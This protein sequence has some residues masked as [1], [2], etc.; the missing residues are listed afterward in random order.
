MPQRRCSIEGCENPRHAR[1]WCASH[2]HRWVR[3]GDP[4]H[5][6]K[7]RKRPTSPT[8][9]IDGCD[10]PHMAR[11]W[12]SA[13]YT[14]WIKTGDPLG[15]TR[16]TPEDRFWAKV[17]K[18]RDGCWVWTAKGT[19]A[20]YGQFRVDGVD[21]YAHRFSYELHVGPI[22]DGL[23]IDHLCRVTSCVNPAHLEPVTGA[24][25]LRRGR[26]ARAAA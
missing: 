8:C 17:D 21:V 16:P 18:C 11:G 6:V 15:S 2:H 25:N 26:E 22:P 23:Q 10:K 14:R 9:I 20:G 1:G 7:T 4:T 13:H 12:C 19:P 24:E 5:P 3:Y